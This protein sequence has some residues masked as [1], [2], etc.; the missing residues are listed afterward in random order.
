MQ[1][2]LSKDPEFAVQQGLSAL[3][4][5]ALA[6]EDVRREWDAAWQSF[7]GTERTYETAES[8]GHSACGRFREWFLLERHSPALVGTPLER[9]IDAWRA[10]SKGF[11]EHVEPLLQASF[12]GIFEVGEVIAQQGAWLRDVS[13]FGEYALADPKSSAQIQSGDLLVGRLF[14]LPGSLHLASGQAMWLRNPELTRALERDLS[15]AR[16]TRRS[17]LRIDAVELERMF[18]SAE[19]GADSGGTSTATAQAPQADPIE[20]AQ[21]AV[22]KAEA[23]LQQAGW[24]P[25]RTAAWLDALKARPWTPGQWTSTPDDPVGQALEALAFESAADLTE[26]RQ[27]LTTAWQALTA[28]GGRTR[29]SANT[30]SPARTPTPRKGSSQPEHQPAA[31]QTPAKPNAERESDPEADAR[32]EALERFDAARAAGG[33]LESQLAALES[34]LGIAPD[35]PEVDREIAPDFPGVVSAMVAEWRWD[36]DRQGLPSLAGDLQPF[37]EFCQP[38]GRFESLSPRDVLSFACFW[39]LERRVWRDAQDAHACMQALSEFCAWASEEHGLELEGSVEATLRGLTANLPRAVELTTQWTEPE[40]ASPR[41]EDPGQL[42]TVPEAGWEIDEGPEQ[43][44]T[45]WLDRQGQQVSLTLPVALLEQLAP[46]DA[47][48]ARLSLQG[49]AEL[50]CFYPPEAH[51][52]ER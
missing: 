23:Y 4:G 40:P 32:R 5:L 46:G 7:T 21:R 20:L 43:A 27:I 26:A 36:R 17:I 49:P 44:S 14:P 28:T 9:L 8:E 50:L 37:E 34:D 52:L 48:R 18:F 42:L 1:E 29:G 3:Q 15:Q 11:Q 35:A 2:R 30:L 51:E 19:W 41:D 22:A 13:G 25:A 6:Q 39:G 38:I 24:T 12:T 47:V 10:S 16:E 45:P 31:T 33:D